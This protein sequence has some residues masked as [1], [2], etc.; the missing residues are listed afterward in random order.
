MS[1]SISHT[2][3]MCVLLQ[4][5]RR[6]GSRGVLLQSHMRSFYYSLTNAHIPS[7]IC[8]CVVVVVDIVLISRE[9]IAVF[10]PTCYSDQTLRYIYSKLFEAS[11]I[12]LSVLI[13]SISSSR[14]QQQQ[15]QGVGERVREI[16]RLRERQIYK[17]SIII[18]ERLL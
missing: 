10:Q 18:Q 3:S 7:D 6:K 11:Q 13:V 16:Q 15:Q 1:H 9:I 8:M 14:A 17:Y 4:R 12:Y 5:E 2:M